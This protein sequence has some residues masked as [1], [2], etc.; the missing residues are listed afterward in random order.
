M[1]DPRHKCFT[2]VYRQAAGSDEI[3][4]FDCIWEAKMDFG[5]GPVSV[6]L[7]GPASTRTY[8]KVANTTGTFNA[9]I[10][11]MQL[12][13]SAGGYDI[14]LRESPTLVSSGRTDI[15]DIGGGL[16]DIDSFFDVYTELSIDGGAWMPQLNQAARITLVPAS[17][18]SVQHATWGAIKS[19]F[20]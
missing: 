20:K 13:G 15:M 2:N 1:S 11:S 5:L 9:E 8:G 17:T 16:Y 6:T 4:T 18:V 19:L 10:I 12:S 14:L 7:T 3:E